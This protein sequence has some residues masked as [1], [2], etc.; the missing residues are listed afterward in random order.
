MKKSTN[1]REREHVPVVIG[2]C[3]PFR[4]ILR[5]TD[6]W[7]PTI[8]QINSREYDYVKLC[9]LSCFIDIGIR[10]FSLGISFDGSLV[11]PA[12][13][14]LSTR[15]SALNKFNET[16]GI[17][18][19]G[20][21]YSEAVQ[22]TDISFGKLFFDGYIKIRPFGKE[23][24]REALFHQSIQTKCVGDLDAIK[25]LHPQVISKA[26]IE[27]AYKKGK[28]YFSKIDKLSPS[29]LLNGTS[30]YVKH[31]WGESIVFLWTSI[32]Q[33]VNII[34]SKEIVENNF[35]NDSLIEGRNKFLKDFRIW[36]TS[37]K[38]ELLYQKGFI[39]NEQ[40]KL[41]NKARKSR[42]DFAHNGK[43]LTQ[44]NAKYALDSLFS[45]IS[46]VISSY[47]SPELLN[48]TLEMIYR[49]QRGDLI[50]KKTTLSIKGAA[51]W[52]P[53]PPLPGDQ[54]WGDKEYEV[55]E[56]LVLKPLNKSK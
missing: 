18:L 21:I 39:K 3:A 13:P 19:L 14:D 50:P 12:S 17:L 20:G 53:L 30:H 25:L 33:V 6:T 5:E 35:D 4:L 38:I 2:N 8:E 55:I 1:K 15:E 48:E 56:D 36:T 16:L 27:E 43:E 31:Q 9:R 41:L 11:L 24:G 26:E 54:N 42:N 34:W 47:Q 23:Y 10:P 40:Y 32:E 37:T 49:N 51:Y 52:L 7:S 45:L 28:I 46:L 29:L 44:E 22:P